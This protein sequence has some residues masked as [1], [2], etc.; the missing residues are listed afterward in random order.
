MRRAVV[1][2]QGPLLVVGKRV[3]ALVAAFQ[4]QISAAMLD[5]LAERQAFADQG[6]WA[7]LR[8]G[9]LPFTL[10]RSRHRDLIYFENEDVRGVYI[11]RAPGQW[12]VE[13]VARATYL[14]THELSDVLALLN[15]LA[16]SLGRVVD[17]RLRRVDLAVDVAGFGLASTDVE[18]VRARAGVDTFVPDAKDIDAAGGEFCKPRLVE[19]RDRRLAVT[20]ITVAPGNPVL[21]RIY[22][23]R[24]EA[25]LPGREEKKE[26]EESI[27]RENEWDGELDVARDEYQ[28]RGFALDEL[29]TDVC[30]IGEPVQA[31]SIHADKL[32]SLVG[33]VGWM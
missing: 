23:K 22:N 3:D 8:I 33:L 10:R 4:V 21:A 18:R 19:H 31:G 14:A 16:S 13:L 32:L 12:N 17:S 29:K 15:G 1:S 28:N 2:R 9:A 27:W 24:A 7:V 25:D 11:G 6:G 30:R 5:E 26:I 20:G